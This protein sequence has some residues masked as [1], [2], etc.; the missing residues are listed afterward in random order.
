M[1]PEGQRTRFAPSSQGQ[2]SSS[3]RSTF[4]AAF[5][6]HQGFEIDAVEGVAFRMGFIDQEQVQQDIVGADR[7]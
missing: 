4:V 1:R 5:P 6:R 2:A 3:C 7:E